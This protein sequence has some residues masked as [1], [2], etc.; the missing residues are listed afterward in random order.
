M[1]ATAVT[2][3]SLDP[4]S[5]LVSLHRDR[6]LYPQ[7]REIGR[8]FNVVL[9]DSRHAG[10]CGRFAGG[11]PQSERFR[12]DAWQDDADGVPVLEGAAAFACR[13]EARLE[14]GTHGVAAARVLEVCLASGGA[15][16]A[17]AEGGLHRLV[18]LDAA[19]LS[20]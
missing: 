1:T 6:T 13:V 7:L 9:L 16:L 15:P 20:S 14:Y 18:P 8:R 3:L 12:G 2:A 11:A 19:L 4:P 10:L 17:Y 5:V